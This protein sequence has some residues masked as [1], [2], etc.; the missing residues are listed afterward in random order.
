MKCEG[1]IQWVKKDENQGKNNRNKSRK[2]AKAHRDYCEICLLG[3]DQM[4]GRNRLEGHH[5]IPVKDGGGDNPENISTLCHR[6]HKLVETYR[7]TLWD[8]VEPRL[9]N[10]AA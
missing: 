3:H 10:K 4:F 9:L 6:C 2:I 7:K 8:I 5:I 1:F